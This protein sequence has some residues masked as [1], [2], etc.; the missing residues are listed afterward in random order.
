MVQQ[1]PGDGQL[2]VVNPLFAKEGLQ[3]E[4]EPTDKEKTEAE[5]ESET[6][7]E[8][9]QSFGDPSKLKEVKEETKYSDKE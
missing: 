8:D 1:P 7:P 6:A 4:S 9:F 5:K 2:P 3:E